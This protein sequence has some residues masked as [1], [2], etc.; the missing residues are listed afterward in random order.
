MQ[1]I[2]KA[3]AAVPLDLAKYNEL[4]EQIIVNSGLIQVS[5]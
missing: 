2:L 1:K 4:C 5:L 3:F